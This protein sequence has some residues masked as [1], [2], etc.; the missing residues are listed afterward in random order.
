M[1]A[2]A[3]RFIAI[4]ALL[5]GVGG[6]LWTV[7]DRRSERQVV[8]LLEHLR[9]TLPVAKPQAGAPMPEVAP[10]GRAALIGL[11]L[12]PV[13]DDVPWRVAVDY[14]RGQAPVATAPLTLPLDDDTEAVEV[15]CL[16]DIGGAAPLIGRQVLKVPPSEGLQ[17]LD[18]EPCGP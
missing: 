18:P 8:L 17:T 6:A 15:R 9:Y 13:G 1:K 2:K 11:R 10:L 16:Y 14:V 7:R 3:Q 4:V 5:A 12:R